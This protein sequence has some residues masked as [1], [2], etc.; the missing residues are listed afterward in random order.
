MYKKI[1]QEKN[2]LEVLLNLDDETHVLETY[3][4]TFRG[5]IG[6]YHIKRRKYLRY[7]LLIRKIIKIFWECV[8]DDLLN[9]DAVIEINKNPYIYLKIS[10]LKNYYSKHYRYN[11]KTQG[12]N[13]RLKIFVSERL[14]DKLNTYFFAKEHK[15]LKRKI[16]EKIDENVTWS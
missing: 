15:I 14:T 11:I 1:I 12:K 10:Y 5:N 6:A 7:T 13:Y 4:K 3:E 9:N 2:D 16:R 8:F